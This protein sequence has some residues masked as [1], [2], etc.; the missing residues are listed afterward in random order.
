MEARS[1]AK[2]HNKLW[3]RN[4]S[5]GEVPGSASIP[6]VEIN[7]DVPRG[8]VHILGYFFN[9][10]WQDE[11]LNMLLRRLQ[12]GRVTRAHRMVEKLAR[13]GVDISFQQVQEL[14]GRGAV[15]RMH[16]ARALVE[17]GYV[18]SPQEAFD[19]YIGRHGP[20]YAER[21]KLTPLEACRAIVQAGGL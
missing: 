19:L 16:V 1:P 15:G 7:T 14:A 6:G 9:D 2:D 10:G 12:E 21:F 4:R 11:K 5:E 20:A 18:D 8:E 13:L 3:H 17:A